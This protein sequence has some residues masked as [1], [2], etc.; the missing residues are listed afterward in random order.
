MSEQK[1]EHLNG[2]YKDIA[3][4]LGLETAK[5]IYTHYK[6]LQVT[7]PVR[8]LSKE[9]IQEKIFREYN[10]SNTRE[11]AR[12]Y[13]YSERWIREIINKIEFEDKEKRV[14]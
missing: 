2:I 8:F 3:E 10:G 13:Q 1:L 9:Y 5:K 14:W 12:K 6:G 4:N 7:F 11:L